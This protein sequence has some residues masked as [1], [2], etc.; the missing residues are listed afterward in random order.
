MATARVK[1]PHLLLYSRDPGPTN[2]LVAAREAILDWP[3]SWSPALSSLANAFPDLNE[4]QIATFIIANTYAH[5]V[6]GRAGVL[7]RQD[8]AQMHSANL[9]FASTCA[10]FSNILKA[11][12]ITGVI[13]GVEDIDEL[14]VRALWHA[15]RL[16]SIPVAILFDATHTPDLRLKSPDDTFFIPDLVVVPD[17]DVG[18]VLCQQ[19]VPLSQIVVSRP[20]YLDYLNHTQ[21]IMPDTAT[22]IR[23]KWCGEGRDDAKLIVLF[24]S[25]NTTEMAALGREGNYCEHHVLTALLEHLQSGCGL[26]EIAPHAAKIKVV[27]RPHPRDP[28]DKYSPYVKF[29]GVDVIIDAEGSPTEAAQ[30]ADLVV[31]MDSALLDEAALMGKPSYSLV[32]HAAFA[33]HPGA[34]LDLELEKQK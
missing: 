11:E 32:A 1:T 24:A 34:F 26:G 10:V 4:R 2:Q 13:T 23:Q 27:I 15:A 3:P 22:R 18:G 14:D 19:G 9:D 29:S 17:H 16:C 31:G 21:N 7:D 12:A 33:K 8:W 5:D 20:G 25:E 28:A 30:A 6:W